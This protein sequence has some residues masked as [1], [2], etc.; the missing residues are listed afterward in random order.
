VFTSTLKY[1]LLAGGGLQLGATAA[2]VVA[3]APPTDKELGE[4]PAWY[5]ESVLNLED[6]LKKFSSYKGIDDAETLEKAEDILL[7]M[8]DLNNSDVLWRLGR[9]FVEKADLIKDPQHKGHL[10]HEAVERCERA[11]Q[12]EPAGGSAGAHKWY[13]IAM[14]KLAE[15]DSKFKKSTKVNDVVADHLQKAV[16]LDPRDPFAWHLLGV[17][18]YRQKNYKEAVD[19]LKKAESI[20]AN[21]SNA[22]FYYLGDALRLAGNKQEAVDYLKKCVLMPIK[23]SENAKAVTNAKLVLINKLKLKSEEIFPHDP[24][25]P[26]TSGK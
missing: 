7:R 26:E 23:G 12:H 4:K 14:S 21:L 18:Y 19:C 1:S 17:Q 22:N 20:H 9:V 3:Y 2:A 16:Q 15:V 25:M 6:T 13:A 10:L 8:E 11:L 24:F 5:R